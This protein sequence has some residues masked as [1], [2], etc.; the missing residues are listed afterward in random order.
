[1]TKCSMVIP[2]KEIWSPP[3]SQS[4][5]TINGLQKV[6]NTFEHSDSLTQTS[7]SHASTT[8]IEMTENTY[9]MTSEDVRKM[10]AQ[11]SKFHGGSIP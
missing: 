3:F 11:E 9:H 10:E 8:G 5:P 7:C 6:S 2:L 4:T 1:M